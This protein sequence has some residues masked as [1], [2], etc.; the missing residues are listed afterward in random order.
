MKPVYIFFI[1]LY[2]V[3]SFSLAQQRSPY[4][5]NVFTRSE[6][7]LNANILSHNKKLVSE[8]ER[9][10]V[11]TKVLENGYVLESRLGQ[12]WD[13][14]DWTNSSMDLYTYNQEGLE[15]EEINQLWNNGSWENSR[16]FLTTYYLND[17]VTLYEEQSW[18]GTEWENSYQYASLYNNDLLLTEY[19]VQQWNGIVWDSLYKT[20]YSYYTSGNLEMVI[21]QM[22][23]GTSWNY[24][25]KY[26]FHYNTNNDVSERLTEEWIEGSWKN[27]LKDIYTYNSQN[28]LELIASFWWSDSIWKES[29]EIYYAYDG[30]GNVIDKITKFWE[31]EIL[32]LQNKYHT[33]YEYLTGTS[34]ETKIENQEWILQLMQ[35]VNTS[36]ETKTYNEENKILN[37]LSEGWDGTAWFPGF[38]ENYF[39][40]ENGNLDILIS[41]FWDGT[42]WVNTFKAIH[43]WTPVTSVETGDPAVSPF[44]YSLEQ[45]YPNP[46]NP[47]TTISFN[48][49]VDA[50]VI[51]KIY[52]SLGEEL[53]TLTN[54]KFTAGFHQIIFEGENLATGVYMY[55]FEAK[56]ND[57]SVYHS[58]KK[59]LMLK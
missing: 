23:N 41:Q 53:I 32:G 12:Y 17:L 33:T 30:K 26:S 52:N 43:V 20:I 9:R 55:L 21:D 6:D 3:Q 36:K 54:S 39:Y 18:N 58:V 1:V 46:F 59:M 40:D 19:D 10:F 24:E 13:G 57:N 38:Q 16:R 34:L 56:G 29:V 11:V 35:W 15:T 14:T 31:G 7:I 5:Q 8:S 49:P 22:W 50:N 51:I 2:L 42:G 47:S 45:N 4:R 44:Q 48:L 28:Q 37:Y 27:S 25:Y